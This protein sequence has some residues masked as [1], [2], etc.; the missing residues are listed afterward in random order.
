MTTPHPAFGRPERIP[1]EGRYVRIEP[2]G[3]QH[4]DGLWEASSTADGAERY[5][6]LPN[7]PPK[8]K[9]ELGAWIDE[10][11]PSEDP[12]YFAIL[13]QATGRC[14]GRQAFLRM[15][16]RD[17]V[18]EI[19]GVYW[20]PRMAKTRLATESLY[21]FA[22]YAFETLGNRRFEW[23]TN[24]RNEASKRAA[25]RFGFTFEGIFRQHMIV[26]GESRDTAWFSMLDSEWPSRKAGLERWLDPANFDSDGTQNTRLSL[27]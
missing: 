27:G 20:G 13:D 7:E 6:W 22:R 18:I 24:N 26:K 1:L 15:V 23:K 14:E 25:Q 16:P 11:V 4:L 2:I 12:L 5:R 3:R 17:G 21:L 10:V 8:D 9:A 19:G